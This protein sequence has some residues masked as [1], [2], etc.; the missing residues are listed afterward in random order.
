MGYIDDNPE[1]WLEKR[2]PSA[3]QVQ[4]LD[5]LLDRSRTWHRLANFFARYAQFSTG[6]RHVALQTS[7]QWAESFNGA[8]SR[9]DYWSE[10]KSIACLNA[11][12]RLR[13]GF[14]LLNLYLFVQHGRVQILRS[15]HGPIGP[16]NGCPLDE[17]DGNHHNVDYVLLRSLGKASNVMDEPEVYG[18]NVLKWIIAKLARLIMGPG[19]KALAPYTMARWAHVADYAG[20]YTPRSADRIY[21]TWQSTAEL[22]SV[23]LFARAWVRCRNSLALA[24]TSN[25][26]IVLYATFFIS[27]VYLLTGHGH[28]L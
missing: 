13:S 4:E 15:A 19:V 23:D 14:V 16:D 24:L 17:L 3:G 10:R 25:E 18:Y 9:P 20:G 8:L 27:L 21:K 1:K 5:L 26:A 2:Q 22:P 12:S 6:Y 7:E 28:I 11:L